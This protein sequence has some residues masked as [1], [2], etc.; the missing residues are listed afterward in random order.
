MVNT[1]RF[2]QREQVSEVIFARMHVHDKV[3]S[4]HSGCRLRV[5]RKDHYL[6]K[7]PYIHFN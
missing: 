1:A 6:K 5:E 3:A 7:R 4:N 2:L